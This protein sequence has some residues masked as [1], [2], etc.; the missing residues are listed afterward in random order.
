M[1]SK[2]N[3]IKT[4]ETSS[5]AVAEK[6]RCRV[7]QFWVGDGVGQTIPGTK[8][9][10]CQETKSIYLLHDKFT[11]IRKMVTLRFELLLGGGL[12]VTYAVHLRLIVKLV[13]DF[14]LVII[15]LFSLDEG[16]RRYERISLG[17]RRF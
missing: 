17:N 8:R 2:V 11:F 16:L 1:S 4:E 15:E 9:C 6:P 14:L 5:S 12:E 10:R 13:V 3:S 7:S